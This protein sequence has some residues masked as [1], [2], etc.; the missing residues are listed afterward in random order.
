M[1]E[2]MWELNSAGE[3]ESAQTAM[4]CMDEDK[5]VRRQEDEGGQTQL[6]SQVP[7]NTLTLRES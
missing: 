1:A 6:Q 5:L 3:E 7:E 2:E 4:I